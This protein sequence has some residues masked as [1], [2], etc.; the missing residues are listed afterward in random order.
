MSNYIKFKAQDSSGRRLIGADIHAYI[1]KQFD[2]NDHPDSIYYLLKH[3]GFSWITSRSKQ[4]QQTQ[5][6]LKLKRSLRSLDI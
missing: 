1:L 4:S 5:D 6:N 2:K 3:M